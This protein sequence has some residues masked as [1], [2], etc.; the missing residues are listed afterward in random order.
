VG[1]RTVNNIVMKVNSKVMVTTVPPDRPLAY[2]RRPIFVSA[3]VLFTCVLAC[4][5]SYVLRQ[6][7]ACF[8][9]T[10]VVFEG[11][12]KVDAATWRKNSDILFK[13]LGFYCQYSFVHM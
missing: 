7:K 10:V 13:I 3:S 4:G 1:R 2:K 8:Q 6:C 12:G 11:R 5:L 9:C